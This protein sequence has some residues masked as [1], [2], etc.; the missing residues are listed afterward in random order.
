MAVSDHLVRV[1]PPS[2]MVSRDTM[3]GSDRRD[4]SLFFGQSYRNLQRTVP[5]ISLTSLYPAV[6]PANQAVEFGN[7]PVHR[8]LV[9]PDIVK[10]QRCRR[11]PCHCVHPDFI[12]NSW[13]PL[14]GACRNFF[15]G[16]ENDLLGSSLRRFQTTGLPRSNTCRGVTAF[17]WSRSKTQLTGSSPL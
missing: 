5:P 2:G 4:W 14:N 17:V 9:C 1:Q 10:R 12:D 3:D 7:D 13:V 15:R 8:R 16:C 11:S 6:L